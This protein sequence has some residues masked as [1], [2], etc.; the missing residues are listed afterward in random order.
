MPVVD[1]YR[2]QDRVVEVSFSQRIRVI[3]TLMVFILQVNSQQPVE[4]VTK[5]I[6]AAMD[7]TFA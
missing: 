3:L 2:K 4:Q 1:Y 7:K 5:D 6:R